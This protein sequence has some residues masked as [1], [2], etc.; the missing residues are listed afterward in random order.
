MR[1]IINFYD[2]ISIY[3]LY[4]ITNIKINLKKFKHNTNTIEASESDYLY[5][6]LSQLPNSGNGLFTAI[7]IYRDEVIS[8]FK[9]EILTDLQAK[10]RAKKGN[11]KYFISMLDGS[12]MDSMHVECF[13]KYANDAE[14]FSKSKFKNCAKISLDEDDNVCIIATRNIKMGE[15]IFCGYGKK[16]WKKLLLI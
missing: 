9:G 8:L 11:D 13:A 6:G 16:Y 12:I 5:T 1:V 14:G 4:T 2:I 7:S 3:I 10:L 15:E